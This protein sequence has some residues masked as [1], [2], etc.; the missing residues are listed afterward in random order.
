[1]GRL[2]V[3]HGPYDHSA[4]RW[5]AARH[6]GPRAAQP[7]LCRPRRPSRR[8][9]ESHHPYCQI[10][11]ATRSNASPEPVSNIALSLGEDVAVIGGLFLI[12]HNPLVA[13]AVILAGAF[14]FLYFAST[15]LRAMKARIW[16]TLAK[17][18]G[19]A[20]TGKNPELPMQVPS[21]F[22]DTFNRENVLK[23]TVDWAVPCISGPGKGIPKNLFGALVATK[24]QPR[25][26]FFVARKN[27][28]PFAQTLDIDRCVIERD[29]RFLADNI[30]ITTEAGKRPR[31]SFR[32]LAAGKVSCRSSD[33]RIARSHQRAH[34][35]DRQGGHRTGP[36]KG[37]TGGV[38]RSWSQVRA[39]G[40]AFSLDRASHRSWR[41]VRL[42]SDVDG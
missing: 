17:L 23:E 36:G 9:R 6:P 18:N 33:R 29:P 26:I 5:R 42:P 30:M 10:D 12:H 31:Y 22:A 19:P 32:V 8:R 35:A 25:S 13:L 37:R 2:G 24:E 4:N 39:L 7:A 16:L 28:R 21:P 27:G 20:D 11:H 15:I 14:V 41:S 34:L 3:G 40:F 38:G 1:M